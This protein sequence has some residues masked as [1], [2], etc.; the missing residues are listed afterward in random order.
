MTDDDKPAINERPFDAKATLDRWSDYWKRFPQFNR[1]PKLTFAQ[2]CGVYIM[3]HDNKIPQAI[4]CQMFGLSR[5]TVSAI[6]GCR[7]DDRRARIIEFEDEASNK[8]R[9]EAIGDD[10][11]LTKRRYIARKQR[12]QRIADEFEYLGAD[13]FRRKYYT[14]LIHE[15]MQ[16]LRRIMTDKTHFA[17]LK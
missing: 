3:L 5:A 6:A 15:R 9:S 12:Y 2:Q 16:N 14:P 11:H 13:E 8:T 4:A 17:K 7:E 1:G 10:G